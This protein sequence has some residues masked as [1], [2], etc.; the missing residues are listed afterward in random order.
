[1]K[2]ETRQEQEEKIIEFP[3][4][5]KKH[6]ERQ[7][8]NKQNKSRFF[9][10]A[11]ILVVVI[12]III[13]NFTIDSTFNSTNSVNTETIS[14]SNANNYD[15]A[16]YKDGYVLAKDGKISCYN[17]NQSV[18]W[19]ITGSKTTPKVTVNE[20][21]VLTYYEDDALAVVTDGDNTININTPGNVQ[22]GFVNSNGYSA[23]LVD[24][25]GLKNKL[26]VYNEKGKMIYYRNNP[27][28]FIPQIILSDDNKSLATLELIT[29]DSSISSC[30]V[31][32]D[33]K[34][35]KEISKIVFDSS[36]PG[37]CIFVDSKTI[38]TVFDSKLIS[39][40][41]NGKQNWEVTFAGKTLYKYSY[42]D[43][44]IACVFNTDDSGT[45]GSEVVFYDDQG[46]NRGEF[47]TTEKIQKIEYKEN[48]VLLTYSK[49]LVLTNLKGKESS[50]ADITYDMKEVHL[51]GTKKCAL[52][53]SN[54]Q[55]AKLLPLK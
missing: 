20:D 38:L 10:F 33:I 27:D 5:D 1:M 25:Y 28:K 22:Y 46:K 39:H 24:E 15:F 49:K 9:V 17:T 45:S 13:C 4:T 54:S 53:V 48:S 23:F 18:Q 3:K 41:T 52:I 40:S 42:N 29:N 7:N 12:V 47:I 14:L 36:V 31:V 35:N 30:L 44:V 55:T 50:Q 11:T 32:T 43:E 2:D 16:S 37:G 26:V 21:F 19:E 6:T 51:M 8:S 34:T